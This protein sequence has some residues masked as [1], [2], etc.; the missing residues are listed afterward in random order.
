MKSLKKQ[1]VHHKK[2]PPVIIS[3]QF[4][5]DGDLQQDRQDHKK[6]EGKGF[7]ENFKDKDYDGSNYK[8]E[9]DYN[10]S[11]LGNGSEAG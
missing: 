7:G 10:S 8:Q 6:Y 4:K 9:D 3:D 1:I 11:K 5:E 2:Q